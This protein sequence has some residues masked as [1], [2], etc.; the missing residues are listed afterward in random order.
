MWREYEQNGNVSTLVI[1]NCF[2]H[3]PGSKAVDNQAAIGM[4]RKA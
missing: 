3:G 2:M 1:W 4:P